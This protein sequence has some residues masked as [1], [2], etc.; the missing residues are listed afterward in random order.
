MKFWIF[1]HFSLNCCW[2]WKH[3]QNNYLE[4]WWHVSN[5]WLFLICW[6]YSRSCWRLPCYSNWKIICFVGQAVAS[7]AVF[8]FGGRTQ[9]ICEIHYWSLMKIIYFKNSF[10][11]LRIFLFYISLITQM[12]FE[13]IEFN[14]KFFALDT[15]R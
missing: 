4:K 12:I 15:V 6:I 13:Q 7:A 9:V 11:S 1:L 3:K 5:S 2:Q 8:H 14:S 10:K